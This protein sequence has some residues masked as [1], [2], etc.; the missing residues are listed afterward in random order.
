MKATTKART[1][2]SSTP[3]PVLVSP[4]V[5]G[6]IIAVYVTDDQLVKKGDLLAKIDPRDY[7][8]A[9]NQAAAQIEQ[10]EATM[11][12]LDA[13]ISAQQDQ[14]AQAS[15]QVTEAQAA[16][17]FAQEED[18]RYQDLARTGSG[19]VRAR[20]AGRVRPKEQTRGA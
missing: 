7:Q 19:T 18:A 6:N 10:A 3:R 8:A 20:S 17:T 4:E 1:T 13:Q 15:H 9:V 12:N 14:I 5:T 2:H 16:L 11:T